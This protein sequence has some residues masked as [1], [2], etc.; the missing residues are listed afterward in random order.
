MRV[1]LPRLSKKSFVGSSLRSPINSWGR[2]AA[3]IY[4]PRSLYCSSLCKNKFGFTPVYEPVWTFSLLR[5]FC[6]SKFYCANFF[7][8]FALRQLWVFKVLTPRIS[9]K[10]AGLVISW[11][12]II[13]TYHLSRER[14]RELTELSSM[15]TVAT[16]LAN[17]SQQCWE[18]HVAL[19]W[20]LAGVFTI[21]SFHF[22]D[23]G[24][25]FIY[26]TVW[27]FI[28]IYFEWRDHWNQQNTI[29][30]WSLYNVLRGL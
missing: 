13:F 27:L 18:L 6:F 5:T 14:E 12:N 26:W 4:P 8:S 23:S 11:K 2:P 7:V 3:S 17:N 9:R 19:T 24:F 29:F 28:L 20:I 16:L 10:F 1:I 30:I 25:Y 22:P 21:T 15:Q